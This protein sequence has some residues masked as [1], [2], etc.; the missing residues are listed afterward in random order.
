[1]RR[2]VPLL[3]LILLLAG[4]GSN[5]LPELAPVHLRGVPDL[6]QEQALFD[7]R[8]NPDT[9]CAPVAVA[10][11]LVW[12][13]GRTDVAHQVEVVNQLAHYRYMVTSPVIGTSPAGLLRG[14]RRYLGEHGIDYVALRYAGWREVPADARDAAMAELRWLH[15]GLDAR[16]AL[17][18]NLGWYRELLPGVF[19]RQGG[20]WVTAVGYDAGRLVVHDPQREAPVEL[21]LRQ[22]GRTLVNARDWKLLAGVLEVPGRP[23]RPG[24]TGFI[25]GAVRLVMPP[26]PAAGEAR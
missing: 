5:E 20:H 3:F 16:A 11:S 18:V 2:A 13:E 7:A 24:E 6:S 1:M 15:A 4:C 9:L 10:N 8:L 19:E 26:G 22:R 21:S 25:E 17:W 14:V 12:L 23:D